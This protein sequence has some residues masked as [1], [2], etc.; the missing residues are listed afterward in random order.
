[1]IIE[2]VPVTTRLRHLLAGPDLLLA[3]GAYDALSAR[4]IAQAGF[5]AVYMTG[6]GT[7]AS[8]LGQPDV[9]LVTMSE[10]VTRAGALTSVLGNLPLI[11]DADTGY[12][13]PLNIR[14]TVREYER[15]GVAALHLEDQ[16]WPKKCGHL[17]GK[18]VIPLEDM[19]QKIRAAVDAREDPDFIIIGRTDANGVC[20][21]HEAIRRAQAY[22]EAGADMLQ[23]EAPKSREEMQLIAETFQGVPLVFNWVESGKMPLLSLEEID[24]LGFKLVLLSVSLLFAATHNVLALLDL[25]KQGQ[26]PT[27][28]G[29]HMVTFSQFTHHIGLPEIQALER[30]Y[31]L[32]QESVAREQL[33]TCS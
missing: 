13:N 29:E 32:A 2:T 17:E 5:P 15:A 4:L 30:R 9:G 26:T 24:Q 25:L 10:M 7:A 14:R 19:V 6:F 31:G 8:A 28:F 16:V 20:G 3:P 1:M 12:G 18:H 23:I 11:A 21:I 33:P 22:H 27:A